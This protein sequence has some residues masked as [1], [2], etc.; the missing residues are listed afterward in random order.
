MENSQGFINK[1]AQ[2]GGKE[3]CQARFKS[4]NEENNRIYNVVGRCSEAK[5]GV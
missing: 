5:Q 3:D 4:L 2:V 1:P